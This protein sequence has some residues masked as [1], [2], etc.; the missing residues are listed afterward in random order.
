M[1]WAFPQAGSAGAPVISSLPSGTS[2]C[3]LEGDAL[4]VGGDSER[5]G[6]RGSVPLLPPPRPARGP[7]DPRR[8]STKTEAVPPS[9]AKEPGPGVGPDEAG[10][11]GSIRP[12]RTPSSPRTRRL[13][14]R[15]WAQRGVPFSGRSVTLDLGGRTPGENSTGHACEA[16]TTTAGTWSCSST[17]GALGEGSR[18]VHSLGTG[19]DDSGAESCSR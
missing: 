10:D 9:R 6:G 5:P 11:A 13:P 7:V 2:K 16:W 19:P 3:A 8:A 4:G 1:G 12:G 14:R 15:D 17:A 18:A